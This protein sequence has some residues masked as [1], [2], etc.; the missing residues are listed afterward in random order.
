ME[1]VPGIQR[2]SGILL[3]GAAGR[4]AFERER[5]K[6]PRFD[7]GSEKQTS[8]PIGNRRPAVFGNRRP[9]SGGETVLR[10]R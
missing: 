5:V 7:R 9:L 6:C 2:Q 1:L 8:D 3:Q 10:D 4:P